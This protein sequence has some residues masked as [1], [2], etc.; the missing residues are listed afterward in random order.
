MHTGATRRA[1][2][3]KAGVSESTV[4]RALS[5]SPLISEETRLRIQKAALALSYI[6]NQQA[7]LLAKKKTLRLGLVVPYYKSIPTFS[8]SYFPMLLDGAITHAEERGYSITIILD[9]EGDQF[10]DLPLL[11]KRKEVDGLLLSILRKGDARINDLRQQNI[12]FVLINSI[13]A[14]AFCVDN[15]PEPG[16]RRAF[17]YTREMG[18]RII[19]FIAG[20][21]KY[22]NAEE[23]FTVF[24]RLAAEFGFSYTVE[25]GNF[26]KTSG[27]CAAG[28]L[29][30]SSPRPTLL[31]T[32]S[33]REALGVLEYC[34]DHKINIPMDIS[35]I[36]FDNLD[37]AGYV[38]PA[39]TTI[40]NPIRDIAL[41]SARL[42]IGI[43]EGKEKEPRVV[44]LDTGF[45][46]RQSSGKAASH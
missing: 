10:K 22:H 36:G 3:K 6:P 5:G 8:R 25:E 33:D 12:S 1:V 37:P 19:G 23:R 4:S 2:A 42:L 11:V 35:L 29:L 15:N 41:E 34:R 46:V 24:K 28:K 17:D 32:S 16:M 18:H 26:S 9:K 7:Y 27:Y 43:I 30:Q 40:D 44:R 45:V 13:A 38:Y 21:M 14:N 20:D 39:L 31:M